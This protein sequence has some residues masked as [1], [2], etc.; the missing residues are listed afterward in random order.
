MKGLSPIAIVVLVTLIPLAG[1]SGF[2]LGSANLFKPTA[3]NLSNQNSV[4][5]ATLPKNNVFNRYMASVNGQI[6]QIQ[7]NTL[8]IKN[9]RGETTR[10][11]ASPKLVVI[12]PLSSN[13]KISSAAGGIKSI[14]L[15][16][17]ANISAE[18]TDG[19]FQIT[20]IIYK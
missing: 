16:K 19:E 4:R 15:Q 3:T 5:D 14:E 8:T 7:D 2:Y 6:S 9:D 20:T 17:S 12:K 1:L 13:P 11:L 18:L 10:L